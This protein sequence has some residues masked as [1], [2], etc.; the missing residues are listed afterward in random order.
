M[1]PRRRGTGGDAGDGTDGDRALAEAVGDLRILALRGEPAGPP[2]PA[3]RRRRRA[4]ATGGGDGAL[5]QPAGAARLLARR[6]GAAPVPHPH[7]GASTRGR[8]RGRRGVPR[9]SPSPTSSPAARRSSCATSAA[10]PSGRRWRRGRWSRWWCAPRTARAC[11][12]RRWP[13]SPR[14]ATAGSRWCWS[15]TAAR[16]RRCRTTIRSPSRR[17]ELAENRG[18]AGAADAGVAAA[19]GDYVAFLDDDDLAAP[20]HLATLVGLVGAA[21]VRVAYTDAAVGVYELE[22]ATP[23]PPER[24]ETAAAGSAGSGASPTAATSIPTCCWSTTTSP[25][26]PCSSSAI[27]SPR[28]APSTATS[29]SSRTGTSS[30]G[31]PPAPPSTTCRG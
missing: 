3:G 1:R 24:L 10:R 9:A 14:G 26:T 15:T 22:R 20:E 28:S 11:S 2:R 13:A 23:A 12:P 16:R 30:S 18:R 29:P 27:S 19:T 4:A 25:S 21:G 5:R 7:P 8:R 6:R 17:V 31:W